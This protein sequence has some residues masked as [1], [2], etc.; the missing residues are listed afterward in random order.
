MV[1]K[2]LAPSVKDGEKAELRTQMLGVASDCQQGFSGGAEQDV[3]DRCL[4]VKGDGGEVSRQ[5]ED[6]MEVRSA[7]RRSSSHWARASDW[8]FGQWRLRHEL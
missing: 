8:H 2:G 4:V 7:D 5:G 6:D 3:I 1:Q